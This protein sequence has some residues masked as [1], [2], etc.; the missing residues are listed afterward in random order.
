MKIHFFK[1]IF[2]PFYTFTSTGNTLEL[3]NILPF[4]LLVWFCGSV[5]QHTK[6]S[7][8]KL[9]F[10]MCDLIGFAQESN[11]KLHFI[12]LSEANRV[13]GNKK[14]SILLYYRFIIGRSWFLLKVGLTTRKAPTPS[15]GSLHRVDLE[16]KMVRYCCPVQH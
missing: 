13:N 10:K 7:L 11:N 14:N 16:V 12:T 4:L 3:V 9:R 1:I 8:L 15:A 2:V 5:Q 6:L